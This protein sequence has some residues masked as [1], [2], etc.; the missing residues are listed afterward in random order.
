MSLA[1]RN[2]LLLTLALFFVELVV[3]AALVKYLL[4]PVAQGSTDDLASLM[5]LS[6]QTWSELP[7]T[8]LC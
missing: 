5:V 4:L 6:A 7:D 1:K 2:T 3:A 8:R